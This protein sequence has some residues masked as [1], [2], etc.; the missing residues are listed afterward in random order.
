MACR[1]PRACTFVCKVQS[2]RQRQ[3]WTTLASST[4]QQRREMQMRLLSNP[5]AHMLAPLLALRCPC[6]GPSECRLNLLFEIKIDSQSWTLCP[7]NTVTIAGSLCSGD[8]KLQPALLCPAGHVASRQNVRS[9]KVWQCWTTC[10]GGAGRYGLPPP[11]LSQASRAWS[12]SGLDMSRARLNR[13]KSVQRLAI[14]L[15]AA[16]RGLRAVPGRSETRSDQSRPSGRQCCLACRL[17]LEGL[18]SYML[19]RLQRLY[20]RVLCQ[21]RAC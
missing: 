4:R 11:Y 20:S 16:L 1:S 14:Q 13:W 9:H 15:R 8:R 2:R 7:S 3:S 17:F 6:C 12:D 18:T 10:L 19:V 21:C 5:A